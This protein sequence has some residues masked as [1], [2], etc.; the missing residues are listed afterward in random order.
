M[1][2]VIQQKRCPKCERVLPLSSFS[3]DK[4]SK[5]GRFCYCK[6]CKKELAKAYYAKHRGEIVKKVA[7]WRKLNKEKKAAYDA[8]YYQAHKDEIKAYKA[9]WRAKN[10]EAIA[11]KHAEWHKANKEKIAEHRAEYYQAHKDEIKAYN[12]EWYQTH[13]DS[14][15]KKRAEYRDPILNPLN[16]ARKI[17][18]HYRDMDRERG[19]DDSK[20]ITAEW[21]LENIAY[22]PCVHCGKQGIGKVGCNRLD[23]TK[24]HTQDNV[25][26]CCM[27][28]NARENIRDQIE[29]GLHWTCKHK[30]QSFKEFVNE[31]KAK[32][33]NLT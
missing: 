10:K 4:S 12:A 32:H 17:V 22:R 27:P 28:C 9:E 5:D 6:D 1:D 21:F 20:T 3:H 14:E 26:S 7:E 11:Q 18:G 15:L 23:N 29:R 31:H 30:K 8:Q 13:R 33:K 24:G 25:E 2:D 16:W 19:F